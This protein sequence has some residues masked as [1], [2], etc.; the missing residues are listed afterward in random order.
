VLTIFEEL[1]MNATRWLATAA[2][3]MLGFTAGTVPLV[4]LAQGAPVRQAAPNPPTMIISIYHVAPGKHLD[5]LRYM[6]QSDAISKEAGVGA[7]QWYAH[8]D[9]DSWDYIGIS[10]ATTD[11]QDKKSDAISK[12]HGLQT[13]FAAGL[14]FRQFISSHTDTFA[15]GPTTAADLVAAAGQR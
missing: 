12:Q 3:G 5:F 14:Q 6:A 10:P 4:C 13:G 7:T 11:E 2:V 1:R 15:R 8:L 9:G